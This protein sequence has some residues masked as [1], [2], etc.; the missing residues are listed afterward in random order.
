M[1]DRATRTPATIAAD[2]AEVERYLVDVPPHNDGGRD[3]L[4]ARR[5]ALQ[6]ELAA[7]HAARSRDERAR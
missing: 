1:T 6:R 3:R 2:L 5:A 7:A 4:E